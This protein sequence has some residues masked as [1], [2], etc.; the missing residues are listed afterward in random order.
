ML[1]DQTMTDVV[2]KPR[3]YDKLSYTKIYQYPRNDNIV[4]MSD[5]Q[6][7]PPSSKKKCLKYWYKH[8]AQFDLPGEWATPGEFFDK[9]GGLLRLN[10]MQEYSSMPNGAKP[11]PSY[12]D[13]RFV[14]V[15]IEKL[16]GT[17]ALYRSYCA[18]DQ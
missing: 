11:L 18:V 12:P 10:G 17:D 16:S 8:I 9:A 4:E 3:T 2:E 1:L 15:I 13:G 14:M 5:L 7:K 6:F